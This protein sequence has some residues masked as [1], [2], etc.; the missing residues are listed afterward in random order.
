MQH[1]L[2]IATTTEFRLATALALLSHISEWSGVTPVP[3]LDV[4]VSRIERLCTMYPKL[5]ALIM[6][7]LS[8]DDLT[9]AIVASETVGI[10]QSEVGDFT[11]DR[12][13]ERQLQNCQEQGTMSAKSTM[14][15]NILKELEAMKPTSHHRLECLWDNESNDYIFETGHKSPIKGAYLLSVFNQT[16]PRHFTNK[17]CEQ[18]W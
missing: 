18:V 12:A 4:D 11:R 9:A 7:A 8:D 15:E 6:L 14:N 1:N 16:W 2:V 3:K 5:H 13:Q 10:V 17:H